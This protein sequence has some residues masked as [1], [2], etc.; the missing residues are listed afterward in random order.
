MTQVAHCLTD[1]YALFQVHGKLLYYTDILL[2]HF[3][4]RK[5]LYDTEVP[6]RI[7]HILVG[8]ARRIPPY[9]Y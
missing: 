2:G 5:C 6:H 3:P 9:L 8:H 7:R 4:A 1:Q